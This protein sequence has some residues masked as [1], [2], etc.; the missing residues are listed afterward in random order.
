MGANPGFREQIGIL[1]V[2][3]VTSP[4]LADHKSPFLVIWLSRLTERHRA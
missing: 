4:M 2:T 1:L 3:F